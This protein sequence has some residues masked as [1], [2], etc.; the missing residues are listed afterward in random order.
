MAQLVICPGAG[1]STVGT[2]LKEQN[3]AH[4]GRAGLE[5]WVVVSSGSSWMC[6]TLQP[7]QWRATFSSPNE[8]LR[9]QQMNWLVLNWHILPEVR[10]AFPADI[11][12]CRQMGSDP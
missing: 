9:Q 10:R 1:V 3:K 4:F 12:E 8:R 2:F 7:F 6:F 5:M 11:S